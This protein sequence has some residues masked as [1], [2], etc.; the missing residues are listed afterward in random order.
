LN[1]CY[2]AGQFHFICHSDTNC[3]LRFVSRNKGIKGIPKVLLVTKQ[4]L[5][6]DLS[7]ND[8]SEASSFSLKEC[9]K[10]T[11]LDLS[12]N[13][14]KKAPDVYNTLTHLTYLNLS[15]CDMLQWLPINF[16]R[17]SSLKELLLPLEG[18]INPPHE[19]VVSGSLPTLEFIRGV[20]Q[21]YLTGRIKILRT[22]LRQIPDELVYSTWA[23]LPPRCFDNMFPTGVGLLSRL[24]ALDCSMNNIQT[25]S[26]AVCRLEFLTQLN[27]AENVV[28][29][30]PSSLH[31][32]TNLT[33]LDLSKNQL[34]ELSEAFFETTSLKVL[35]LQDNLLKI[36]PNSLQKLVLLSRCSLAQ[37]QLYELPHTITKLLNLTSFDVV[38]KNS[39]IFQ[40]ALHF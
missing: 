18:M 34:Q 17:M 19:V 24:S 15:K 1:F 27:I 23:T 9:S 21:G 36:I 12:S 10:L 4:L 39:T 7:Q 40:F 29:H 25:I 37:N 16:G 11:Y 22:C 3:I 6:L 5:K 30:I 20:W 28:R 33:F 26:F 38:S 35:Y 31:M 2:G 32:L 8:I 14:L 13:P